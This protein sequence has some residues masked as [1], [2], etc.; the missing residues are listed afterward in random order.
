[1][2][3][4]DEFNQDGAP[5]PADWV[6]EEGFERNRELQWY[7]AENARCENGLLII[8]ARRESRPNPRFQAG[9]KDWRFQ[10]E[11]IE[12][13]S[14]SVTTR[15][16]HAWLYGKFEV[17]ARIDA[18]PGL[19]PAIWTLGVDGMWPAN[20]EVDL[21]EFYR[22][23]IL[24]N[25]FWPS[26]KAWKPTGSVVK[27]PL[28]ELGGADWAKQFH[29]WRMEWDHE[30][31]RIYVD[32][33]LLNRTVLTEEMRRDPKAPHPFRQP[34]YVLLN[35]AL[36]S[37]GGDPSKTEFPSRFEVDYVRIYQRR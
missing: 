25:L 17:R 1:M 14:A 26:A 24:A 31:I 29:V 32:E 33:L 35:L 13:T 6:F 18:R 5:N 15:G 9:S 7:Q 34:H 11:N 8:E 2:V 10:R 12:Y 20:G 22:E 21:M 28:S 4:A 16:K 19:W 37:S 23:M 30:E 36:G 3:W 27:K